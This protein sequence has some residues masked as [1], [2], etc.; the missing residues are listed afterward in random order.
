M[1][2]RYLCVTEAAEVFWA[3][4]PEFLLADSASLH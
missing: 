1:K 2:G 4:V 3:E